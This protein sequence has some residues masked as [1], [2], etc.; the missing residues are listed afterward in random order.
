MVNDPTRLDAVF[1]ALADPTRRRIV[2]K[3]AKGSL[4][5]GQIADGFPMTQPAISKHV[6]VLED[7]G[8]LTR[9][10]VGRVHRCRLS[11]EAVD[12]AAMWLQRQRKYWNAALE[13]L[14]DLLTRPTQR[15]KR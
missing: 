1:S 12:G 14:D 9:E 15:K 6:R 4:T 3:L 5:V 10:I 11:P 7:S 13:R 2:E 8:L